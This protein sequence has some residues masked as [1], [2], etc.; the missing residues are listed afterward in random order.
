MRKINRALISV[1]DKT[2]LRFLL[3]KLDKFNNK[4]ISSGGTY[5]NQKDGFQCEEVSNIQIVLKFCQEGLRHCT[6]RYMP[7]YYQIEN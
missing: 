4:F 3:E 5:R 7:V 1:S 2:N 6:Q